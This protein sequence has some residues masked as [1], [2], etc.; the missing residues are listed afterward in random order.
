MAKKKLKLKKLSKLTSDEWVSHYVKRYLRVNN[1]VVPKEKIIPTFSNNVYK[2]VAEFEKDYLEISKVKDFNRN[3]KAQLKKQNSLLRELK[4]HI[5]VV[6]P[7]LHWF[8]VD[9]DGVTYAIG[10]S[11]SNWGGGESYLH[12]EKYKEGMQLKVL[13]HYNS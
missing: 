7:S 11:T 12:V 10:Q 1:M 5:T 2:S 8:L 9:V 4:K 13:K 3:I 6:L